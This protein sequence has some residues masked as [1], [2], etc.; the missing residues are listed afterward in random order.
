MTDKNTSKEIN[1]GPVSGTAVHITYYT[2]V[3]DGKWNSAGG[4]RDGFLTRP[5]GKY[6]TDQIINN[7]LSEIMSLNTQRRM[8]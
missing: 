2:V 7:V 6:T 8:I 3:K 5:V 4:Y 1:E